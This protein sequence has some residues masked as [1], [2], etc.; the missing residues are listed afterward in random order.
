MPLKREEVEDGSVSIDDMEVGQ[1]ARIVEWGTDKKLIG[2]LL[3][4]GTN[5][6]WYNLTNGECW[7]TP[8]PGVEKWDD[9]NEG[10]FCVVVLPI[11]SQLTVC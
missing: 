8:A 6:R 9:R 7:V 2:L 4:R 3:Y 11:G 5:S 1:V 10:K